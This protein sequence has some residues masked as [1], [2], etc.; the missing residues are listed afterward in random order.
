MARHYLFLHRTFAEYLTAEHLAVSGTWRD[1][2]DKH[3]WFDP[4]WE[5]VILLLGGLL[6][7]PEDLLDHLLDVEQDPLHHALKTAARVCGELALTED[8]R[9][10][11]RAE[12]IAN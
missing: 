12:V 6:Q 11:L 8:N 9:V 4:E 5:Q 2:V 10:A 1:A 7:H 3:Q